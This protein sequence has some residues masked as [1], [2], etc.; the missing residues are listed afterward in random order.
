MKQ[1]ARRVQKLL[2]VVSLV[3]M[4]SISGPTCADEREDLEVVR[5]TTINLIFALVEKGVLTQEAAQ[6]LVKQAEDGA[7]KKVAAATGAGEKVVR[8]PYVPESVKRE[9]REQIKQEVVAQA[10]TERWGDANVLPDWINRLKWE[11]DIRLRY[12]TDRFPSS[13]TTPP[14][15]FAA[16]GQNGVT[17]TTEQRDRARL[18]AR[19]GLLAQVTPGISAGF[20]LTTGNTLDP[21]S[22]NQ[23]LGTYANKYTLV[24]DRAYLKLDPW[25]SFTVSGGRIPNP[26]FSTD[27]VWDDDLNFE[28][29]AASFRKS[30]ASIDA[31]RPFVTLGAYSLQEFER[32]NTQLAK[33]KWFWGA[34]GGFEWRGSD[35]ARFKLGLAYYDFLNVKGIPNPIGTNG[36]GPYDPT[37]AFFRQKGNT[38]FDINNNNINPNIPLYGLAADF[39]LVNLT[40][41][42][43]LAH[44]DPV[45]VMLTG[46][47]V[48]N[49]GYNQAEIAARTNRTDTVPEVT[50]WQGR[51]TVGMPV[52]RD[53]HDWQ[54]FGGYRYVQRDAVLDA[55][56]D[57]DFHLGGTDTKGYFIGA[58]Y[59]VDKNTWLS[60]R[61]LS[62]DQISGLPLAIDVLQLDLNAKF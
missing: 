40:G 4:V 18:R 28:G 24:F 41:S 34:Q 17:N 58:S 53:L 11:G 25:E 12:Q 54:I 15:V 60:L 8:V 20:R 48:K 59:G 62:A 14:Q 42:L 3:G 21:V 33:N 7:R 46:D 52:I 51:I 31:F 9:I 16:A 45:H 29:V 22:T 57:S 61:W 6:A 56:T 49:V 19:L 44:F 38:T 13:N 27:L 36:A 50:G 23:T 1:H 32:S 43:D 39:K 10:K 37:N 2:T 35:Q 5:Q 55:F 26:Y 30:N 47:Y